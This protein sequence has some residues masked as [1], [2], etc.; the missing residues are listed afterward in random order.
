MINII[1]RKDGF[2]ICGHAQYAEP[3]RDIVCAAVSALTQTLV[4]SIEQ[5]TEDKIE[6]KLEHGMTV[7]KYWTL[8][9]QAK[10]LIA[11]FFIGC[12]MIADQYPKNV[13]I[14]DCK[15]ETK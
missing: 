12:E 2:M 6:Y 13:K 11:S 5:L 3:G 14:V 1:R 7:V 10:V 9:D 4:E 15:E 8:S